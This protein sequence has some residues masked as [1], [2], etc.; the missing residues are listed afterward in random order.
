VSEHGFGKRSKVDEY[1]KTARGSKGVKTLNITE[2][3]GSLAAIKAVTDDH[4]LMIINRS[5]ITIRMTASDIRRR[6]RHPG[7][8]AHQHTRG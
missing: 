8:Q 3:T 6:T 2:K 1:R 7:R 5:G 4:D